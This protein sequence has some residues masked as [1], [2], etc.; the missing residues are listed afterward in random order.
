[1][2]MRCIVWYTVVFGRIRLFL[3]FLF[4]AF[5]NVFAVFLAI[6]AVLF[7]RS[8]DRGLENVKRHSDE[9]IVSL[10]LVPVHQRIEQ[11]PFLTLRQDLTD[12]FVIV[13]V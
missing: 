7:L 13:A 2:S 8:P 11:I 3:T 9:L 4:P 1:M 12:V 6:I 10:I 5:I